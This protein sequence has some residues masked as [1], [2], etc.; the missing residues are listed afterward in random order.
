MK[1]LILVIIL[2]PQIG[3]SKEYLF[4]YNFREDGQVKTLKYKTDADSWQVAFDRGATFCYNFFDKMKSFDEDRL[5]RV[6]DTCANPSE[7]K[8]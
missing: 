5:V 8:R 1:W 2:V 3:I 4:T 6:I 7:P